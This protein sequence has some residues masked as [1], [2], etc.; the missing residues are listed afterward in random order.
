[1]RLR[2][3]CAHTALLL[4]ALDALNDGTVGVPVQPLPEPAPLH[5]PC[6]GTQ[7]LRA[8]VRYIPAPGSPWRLVRGTYHEGDAAQGRHHI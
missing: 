3:W 2:Q 7:S 1:M 6:N 4:Q 8:G 5:R